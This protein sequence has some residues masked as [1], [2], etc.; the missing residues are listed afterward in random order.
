MWGADEYNAA[1]KE[2]EQ[3]LMSLLSAA[4]DYRKRFMV[5]REALAR[6]EHDPSVNVPDAGLF[7]G[8]YYDEI[9]EAVQRAARTLASLHDR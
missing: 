9:N 6:H 4:V 2:S 1:F 5:Y 7:M 3:A 8:A